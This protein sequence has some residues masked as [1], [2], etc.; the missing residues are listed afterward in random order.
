MTSG[1]FCPQ[2]FETAPNPL[3]GGSTDKERR[4]PPALRQTKKRSFAARAFAGAG[5]AY[6]TGCPCIKSIWSPTYILLA[7]GLS[8]A[9]LG[10]L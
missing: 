8:F 1:R 3:P 10:A 7:G 2:W 6:L 9:L 5:L 4:L